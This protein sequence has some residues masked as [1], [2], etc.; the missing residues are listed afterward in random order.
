MKFSLQMET[1][2]DRPG[3][4]IANA[5]RLAAD[6]IEK[7]TVFEQG[8]LRAPISG[9]VVCEWSEVEEEEA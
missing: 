4:P 9:D 6:V 1:N 3:I 2:A 7:Q 8:V 5:M